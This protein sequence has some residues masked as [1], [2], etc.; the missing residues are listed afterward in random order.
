MII[1][2]EGTSSN[3]LICCIIAQGEFYNNTKPIV[4]I[5]SNFLECCYFYHLREMLLTFLILFASRLSSNWFRIYFITQYFT[6]CLLSGAE[7]S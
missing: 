7:R 3:V 1:K 5:V 4:W 2:L 6:M